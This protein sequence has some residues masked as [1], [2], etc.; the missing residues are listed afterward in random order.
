MSDFF[1]TVLNSAARKVCVIAGTGSGKTT[2][3]LLPKLQ[4]IHANPNV[5]PGEV[6]VLTSSQ[7]AIRD[8]QRRSEAFR[9]RPNATTVRD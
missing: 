9:V 7:V 4:Q 3:I 6:V 5:S 8:L 1:E 2:R